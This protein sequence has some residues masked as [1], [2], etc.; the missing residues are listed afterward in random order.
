MRIAPQ[1]KIDQCID[2]LK[3]T[4]FSFISTRSLLQDPEFIEFVQTLDVKIEEQDVREIIKDIILISSIIPAKIKT[5]GKI[6]SY[7]M[8]L[9]NLAVMS[10]LKRVAEADSIEDTPLS[11]LPIQRFSEFNLAQKIFHLSL[12]N[13]WSKGQEKIMNSGYFNL[14]KSSPRLLDWMLA[15]SGPL[16]QNYLNSCALTNRLQ[17]FLMKAP[18]I[19]TVLIIN[20]ELIEEYR[21]VD[22][23]EQQIFESVERELILIKKE[24]LELLHREHY[25]RK[26]SYAEKEKLKRRWSKVMQKFGLLKSKSHP[27]P[28]AINNHWTLSA[29]LAIPV[30]LFKQ[31]TGLHRRGKPNAPNIRMRARGGIPNELGVFKNLLGCFYD[32]RRD[33]GEDPPSLNDF[34]DQSINEQRAIV[35]KL[36]TSVNWDDGYNLTGGGSHINVLGRSLHLPRHSLYLRAIENSA[37]EK[38]FLLLDPKVDSYR[39]LTFEKMRTYIIRR[40]LFPQID[41]IY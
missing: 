3:A 31:A 22:E 13:F 8:P 12:L 35:K 39:G 28:K 38:V 23:Y 10:L 20:E 19:L 25:G 36:W 24:A 7:F 2:E 18:D 41:I 5:N 30:V 17:E 11:R 26:V 27:T 21:Y 1:V 34:G 4:G 15:S 14:M 9:S 33:R 16:E 37:G 32:I 29:V 6:S 40:R